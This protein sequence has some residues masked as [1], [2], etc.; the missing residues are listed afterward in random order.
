[1][2]I[3]RKRA[4][5]LP[6]PGQKQ[7]GACMDRAG[8]A[9]NLHSMKTPS[10]SSPNPPLHRADTRPA[11]AAPNSKQCLCQPGCFGCLNKKLPLPRAH[12]QFI[13]IK[14]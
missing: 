12:I 14:W 10:S 1:M 2:A 11:L 9:A 7:K 4:E 5:G 6:Q 3:V 13:A 8:L